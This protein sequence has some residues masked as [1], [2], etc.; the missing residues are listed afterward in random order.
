MFRIC[1][2]GDAQGSCPQDCPLCGAS[3]CLAAEEFGAAWPIEHLL[4]SCPCVTAPG[5]RAPQ[6]SHL[7]CEDLLLATADDAPARRLFWSAFPDG[8]LPVAV[9][10]ACS[11]PFLLDP[12][13]ALRSAPSVRGG[14]VTACASLVAAFIVGVASRVCGDSASAVAAAV[15]PCLAVPRGASVLSLLPA[16]PA[17]RQGIVAEGGVPVGA[18]CECALSAHRLVG[19]EADAR[20]G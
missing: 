10:L 12:V 13:H 20:P 8:P 11:V 14:T 3:V 15:A 7:R 17:A 18:L 6:A 9:S 2:N 4:L 19:A 5:A 1:A 16:V